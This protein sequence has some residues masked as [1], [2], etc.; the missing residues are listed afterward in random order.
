MHDSRS[1]R[2]S[3]AHRDAASCVSI[4]RA[5]PR[6]VRRHASSRSN[7]THT[8]SSRYR[9]RTRDSSSLDRLRTESASPCTRA[10]REPRSRAAA[11]KRRWATPSS[12]P[13][14]VEGGVAQLLVTFALPE[15]AGA[16][17]AVPLALRYVPGAP[18]YE[19]GEE[20]VW[21]LPLR[22]RSPLR[23]VWVLL[24][25]LA[26]A[27]WFTIARA[28]RAKAMAKAPPRPH[29]APR[30]G[31]AKLDVVRLARN[32]GDGWRGRVTDADDGTGI[33][34]AR[35]QIERPAFGRAETPATTITQDDGRFELPPPRHAPAMSSRLQRRSL[36]LSGDP[37][38]TPASS[39]H[40]SSRESAPCSGD[41]WCGRSFEGARSTPA[42]S[43]RP[44]TS[45]V[46]Q[47]RT[48]GS[49]DG[50]IAVERA[51]FAG[52]PVDARLEAE[53]DRLAPGH[54]PAEA[55]P[56]V[57]DRRVLANPTKPNR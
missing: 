2:R 23:Q 53:I 35:V 25:G 55:R 42:L 21:R 34:G 29:P 10:P 14:P 43:R 20:S 1:R 57:A 50:R 8:S 49:P 51:A 4:S 54:A 32:A 45:D 18:W 31:E 13:Q 6:Q 5:P 22:S 44:A 48:S 33:G 7:D 26:V 40:S 38:P 37:S 52:E 15:S 39:T 56:P 9:K 19:G 3:S 41:W 46:P 17:G 16:S 36:C 27:L 24:G 12:A 30:G 11:W 47:E 28:Q